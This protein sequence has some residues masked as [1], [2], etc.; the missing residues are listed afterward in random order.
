MMEIGKEEEISLPSP[1]RP[2]ESG[3]LSGERKR[4]LGSKG[5]VLTIKYWGNGA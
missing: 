5:W 4:A 2:K 3:K 1:Q